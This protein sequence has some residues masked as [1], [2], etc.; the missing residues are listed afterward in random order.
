MRTFICF[1]LCASI[2]VLCACSK[3]SG[4][5]YKEVEDYQKGSSTGYTIKYDDN[6]FD[7]VKKDDFDYLVLKSLGKSSEQ[8]NSISIYKVENTD[9]QTQARNIEELYKNNETRFDID[10]QTVSVSDSQILENAKC[11]SA[12]AQNGEIVC[13]TQLIQDNGDV[14]VIEYNFSTSLDD[15]SIENAIYATVSSFKLK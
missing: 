5:F 4:S 1:V 2:F 13:E 14:F 12:L 3:K 7:Y 10:A 15:V 9:I 8:E 11:V 6:L